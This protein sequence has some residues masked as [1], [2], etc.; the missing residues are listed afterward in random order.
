MHSVAGGDGTCNDKDDIEL[1]T[2]VAVHKEIQYS[3]PQEDK[4]C[5]KCSAYKGHLQKNN[6]C[7]DEGV[8]LYITKT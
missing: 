2:G 5:Y 8:M 6:K 3:D 1:L 7:H 4:C